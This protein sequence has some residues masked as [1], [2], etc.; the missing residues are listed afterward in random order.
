ML[1]LIYFSFICKTPTQV[2]KLKAI[3]GAHTANMSG[4]LSVWPKAKDKSLKQNVKTHVISPSVI[5][6]KLSDFLSVFI[7]KIDANAVIINRKKGN[8]S[9]ECKL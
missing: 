6:L 5:N 9:I 1:E 2:N 8:E 7:V 4:I 3:T